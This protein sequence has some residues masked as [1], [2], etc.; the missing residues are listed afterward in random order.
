M[1]A[2]QYAAHI[3]ICPIGTAFAKIANRIAHCPNIRIVAI[4]PTIG[5]IE[6]GFTFI[7]KIS[8]PFSFFKS[9]KRFHD[10]RTMEGI[11]LQLKNHIYNKL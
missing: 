1:C 2:K 3:P 11:S 10:L 8:L 4:C 9:D 6:R 5:I 7:S